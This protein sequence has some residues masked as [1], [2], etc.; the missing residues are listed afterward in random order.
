[1]SAS[2][3]PR[4]STPCGRMHAPRP[5]L[6]SERPT[7]VEA[8]LPN[9]RDRRAVLGALLGRRPLLYR[10]VLAAKGRS[11]T[12]ATHVYLDVSG[13]MEPYLPL[14]YGALGAAR[15][16]GLT[17]TGGGLWLLT[18]PAYQFVRH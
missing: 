4:K 13:S 17:R 5:A 11:G 8:P 3:L 16:S 18:N 1:M 2:A 10:D 14:L 7:S 6:F 15:F 9:A 12:G